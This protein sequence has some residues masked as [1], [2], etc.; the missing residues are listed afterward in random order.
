MIADGTPE[1]VFSQVELLQSVGLT[2]PETTL[3]LYELNKAGFDLP[4]EAL[5]VDACAQVL[6]GFLQE[7]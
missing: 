5:S 4:L 7:T 1:Q 3:L 6:K 2:V